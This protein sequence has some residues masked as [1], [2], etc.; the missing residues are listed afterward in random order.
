MLYFLSSVVA[1]QYLT[2]S[3]K[4]AGC[5]VVVLNIFTFD[6]VREGMEN[7]NDGFVH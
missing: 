4:C 5:F 3:S 1:E 7:R 6:A 2:L